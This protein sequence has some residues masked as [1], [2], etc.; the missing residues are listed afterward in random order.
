MPFCPRAREST[1][2]ANPGFAYLP[3]KAYV[4]LRFRGHGGPPC[5]NSYSV[6]AKS[7]EEPAGSFGVRNTGAPAVGKAKSAGRASGVNKMPYVAT[8]ENTTGGLLTSPCPSSGRARHARCF[9]F[10]GAQTAASG[11]LLDNAKAMYVPP[12]GEPHL[13]P[14]APITTYWRPSTS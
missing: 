4:K 10:R 14:P 13:P 2:C 3:E 7:A 8:G 5:R 12:E 11:H 1:L 6:N 9:A